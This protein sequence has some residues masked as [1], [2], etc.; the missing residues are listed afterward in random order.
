M[1][2]LSERT[3]NSLRAAFARFDKIE[4]VVIF[5]SRAKGNYRPGSDIDLAIFAS[6]F[7]YHDMMALR[8]AVEDIGL[9]YM[10]D[11]L[12]YKEITEPAL[13]EHIDRAGQIF[14]QKTE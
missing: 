8:R 9:L 4:R 6:D 7:T 10:I 11:L 2:G 13:T 5:G 1:F 14:Y 12:D 3:L